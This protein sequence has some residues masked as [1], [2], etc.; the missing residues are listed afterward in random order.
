M[1]ALTGAEDAL[2]VNNNAA[3][4]VLTLSCLANRKEVLVSRGELIE[5]GGEFR[6][7]EIMSASGAKLVEVGTTNRT[8]PA[9]YQRAL[10][11]KTGLILKVHPSNYRVVG[12]TNSVGLTDL[13]RIAGRAGVPLVYDV[14]SGL[15]DRHSSVPAEEPN[16]T[17]ALGGGADLVTFSGDK[18]L[19]GP[20]T[21]LVVGRAALVERLRRHPIAR[22]V[23]VDKM[24][25]AALESVLRLYATGRRDEIPV[26][27]SLTSSQPHLLKRARG[28]AAIFPVASAQKSDAAVGGGWVPGYAVPS[29]EL[30]LPVASPSRAA[31]RLRLGRPPVFC[32]VEDQSLVFDLSTVLEKDEDRLVRAIRYALEQD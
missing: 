6:L 20:Q 18:L 29:A 14:G 13:A 12:F 5:I 25:V 28:L 15:L 11:P 27:K 10:G 30:V 8:R 7:P 4:L 1:R 23:R 21:G 19:G 26:W 3:A 24:T 31:A 32:R 2:A 16:V 22:A 17:D 9:D